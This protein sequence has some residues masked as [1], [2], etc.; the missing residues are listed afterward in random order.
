[1]GQVTRAWRAAID[2]CARNPAR[3]A[4][5]PSWQQ[6]LARVAEGQQVTFGAFE[7]RWR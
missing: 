7:R 5:E 3:F 6:A 2:A 1:V 4:P